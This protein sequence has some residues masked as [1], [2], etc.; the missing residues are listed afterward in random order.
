MPMAGTGMNATWLSRTIPPAKPLHSSL[1]RTITGHQKDFGDLVRFWRTRYLVIPSE[2]RPIERRADAGFGEILS[3]EEC[4]LLG[5]TRLADLFHKAR[6]LGPDDSL[7]QF[8]VPQFLPTTL[9]PS[10]S[11][12]DDDLMAQLDQSNATAATGKPRLSDKELEGMSLLNVAQ[13][14]REEHGLIQ[15][16]Q[17]HGN[18]YPDSFTG[19]SWVTWAVRAFRDVS[20]REEAENMGARFLK[21]GLFAHVRREHAFMDG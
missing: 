18:V 13:A 5:I 21:E 12:L 4:R 16:N 10:A 15:D 17:W 1:D 8:A 19:Q 3:D 6:W 9:D 11:V 7:D 20:T 2:E 14:M